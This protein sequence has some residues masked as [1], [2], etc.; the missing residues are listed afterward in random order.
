MNHQQ[1]GNCEPVSVASRR[2]QLVPSLGFTDASF[3][4]PF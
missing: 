3:A 4:V 2:S 1:R